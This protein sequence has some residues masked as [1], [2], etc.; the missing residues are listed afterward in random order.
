MSNK[1]LTI[2]DVAK[3]LRLTEKT[4]Y[5]LTSEVKLPGSK[6]GGSWRCR[7]TDIDA[8]IEKKKK[9]ADG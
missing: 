5:R 4:A 6:T 2:K 3:F 1:I 9:N 7:R 8:W